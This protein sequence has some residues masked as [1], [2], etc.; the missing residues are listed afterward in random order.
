[1][2][3]SFLEG[4][5]FAG[6]PMVADERGIGVKNCKKLPTS[7]LDGPKVVMAYFMFLLLRPCRKLRGQKISKQYHSINIHEILK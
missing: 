6:M 5:H 4:G 7:S 3:T 2:P 1:M